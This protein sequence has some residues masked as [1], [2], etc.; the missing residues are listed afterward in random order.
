ML[1]RNLKLCLLYLKRNE[2]DDILI[3]WVSLNKLDLLMRN[4]FYATKT[5]K[6]QNKLHSKAIWF[7]ANGLT[8]ACVDEDSVVSPHTTTKSPP[9]WSQSSRS[10]EHFFYVVFLWNEFNL[11]E[12]QEKCFELFYAVRIIYFWIPKCL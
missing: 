11:N 10:M 1:K 5:P 6:L 8:E 7:H 12:N 3:C 2:D 4:S 9:Q